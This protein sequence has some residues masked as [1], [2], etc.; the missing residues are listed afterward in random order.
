[1]DISSLIFFRLGK[2][3]FYK[4]FDGFPSGIYDRSCLII[5]VLPSFCVNKIPL[6]RAC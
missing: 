1:M 3:V 5:L 4:F 6:F 2:H